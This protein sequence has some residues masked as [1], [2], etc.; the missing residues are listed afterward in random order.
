[1]DKTKGEIT[2]KQ[3]QLADN[4][5]GNPGTL[6][7]LTIIVSLNGQVSVTFNF[8]GKVGQQPISKGQN[9]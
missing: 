9:M 1:M 6:N 7:L 4:Q 2:V 3:S 8:S 5:S